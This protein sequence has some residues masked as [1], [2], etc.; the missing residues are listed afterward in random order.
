MIKDILASLKDHRKP[1]LLLALTW[2]TYF[3]ALFLRILEMKPDGIYG[4]H[5][6]VWA[7]WSLHIG[8]V[9][10]FAYKSPH[11]WFA[12]HPIYS[13]GRF[14]YPF[15]TNL[16]SGLLVRA[17][18]PLVPAMT[19]P[20]VAYAFA[21]LTGL[22]LLLHS[23]V[24]SRRQAVLVIFLFLFLSGP[25]VFRY[26]RDLISHFSWNAVLFPPR[27]YSRIDAHQWYAGNVIEG[28]LAPQR[29]FLL[30][31][32]LAVWALYATFRS[33]EVRGLGR[34][35][36]RKYWVLAGV[37][38]GLLPFT[39]AHSLIAITLGLTLVLA[40]AAFRS[41]ELWRDLPYL[42]VPSVSLASIYY[43]FFL[44]GGIQAAHFQSWAPGWTAAGGFTGWLTLWLRI[45][46]VAIPFAL[47]SFVRW[48]GERNSVSACAK[49]LVG[50]FFFCSASPT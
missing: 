3:I 33:L 46:G 38:I 27:D 45:W 24:R 21:L 18:V 11:D 30:G 23:L 47:V 49:I 13:E 37:L 7:D 4:G 31:M 36:A 41:P 17:G 6:N 5:I 9:N 12:Y 19:I 22:Y 50:S 1:L 26:L 8:M 16:L 15:L 35:L 28:L 2:G 44:R 40:Y 25:G 29:A 34:A 14:T 10:L 42:G 20:S 39:H 48:A 32:T 43:I